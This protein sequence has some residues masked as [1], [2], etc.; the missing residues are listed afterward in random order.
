MHY[1]VMTRACVLVILL[2]ACDPE[3]SESPPVHGPAPRTVLAVRAASPRPE[4]AAEPARFEDAEVEDDPDGDDGDDGDGG[5]DEADEADPAA[6][7]DRDHLIDTDD[8]CPDD[9]EDLDGFEDTDGCPDADVDHE[10]ILEIEDRC[11]DDPGDGDDLD[12]CP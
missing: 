7:A 9:P 2:G 6:D 5:D 4:L 3:T 12:G 8:Q 1:G 11:P 10:G